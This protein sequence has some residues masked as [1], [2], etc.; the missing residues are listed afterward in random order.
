M[1]K[2]SNKKLYAYGSDQQL[3]V[4]GT[5]SAAVRTDQN[6]VEAEFS[7]IDGKS[8]CH[9]AGCVEIRHPTLFSDI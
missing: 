2:K 8:N 9:T 1:S 4:L 3:K 6:E 7:V 5:F